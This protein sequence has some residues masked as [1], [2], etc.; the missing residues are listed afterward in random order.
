MQRVLECKPSGITGSGFDSTT[1]T[2]EASTSASCLRSAH[3]MLGAILKNSVGR[4]SNVRLLRQ[5]RDLR[6][7]LG[8][9][10]L[11]QD[12]LS[13]RSGKNSIRRG[14]PRRLN[15]PCPSGRVLVCFSFNS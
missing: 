5:C 4:P 12:P 13:G 1:D 11:Y 8:P 10:I 9:D 6:A 3:S 15:S 7:R 2:S 14:L